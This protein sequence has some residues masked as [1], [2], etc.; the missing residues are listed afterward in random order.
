MFDEPPSLSEYIHSTLM[1]VVYLVASNGGIAI[2]SDPH[3]R[4]IIRMD[5]VV[6]EL[7]WAT[8]MYIYTACLPMMNLTEGNCWVGTCL[9]FKASDSVV[10]NVIG[11]KVALLK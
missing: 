11:M 7:T 8:F 4:K 6:N 9:H 2:W 1:T 10:M 3:T 5:L